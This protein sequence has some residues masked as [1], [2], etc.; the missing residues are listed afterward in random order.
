[1]NLIQLPD[2][3][4]D[5]S[6]WEVGGGHRAARVG[7]GHATSITPV[8]WGQQDA[9]TAQRWGTGA[10]SPTLGAA[11][12]RLHESAHADTRWNDRCHHV[13]VSPVTGL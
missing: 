8:S 11:P 7:P 6:R 5:S 3:R 9:A 12:A 4:A 13:S 1:M 2:A 10:H